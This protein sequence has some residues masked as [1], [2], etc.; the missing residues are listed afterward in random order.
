MAVA[1]GPFMEI[2][3]SGIVTDGRRLWGAEWWLGDLDVF[4]EPMRGRP[5][6]FQ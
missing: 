5:A 4:R 1:N 3:A 6:H 2:V